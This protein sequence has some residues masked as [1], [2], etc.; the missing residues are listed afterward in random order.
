M[1]AL[2]FILG[3]YSIIA[4]LGLSALVKGVAQ[5]IGARERL[6]LYWVHTCWI[7]ILFGIQIVAW[8]GLWQLR[9]HTAWS[10]LEA[11]MLLL[12]PI[13]FN[14][15]S[16]LAAPAL[17]EGSEFDMRTYYFQQAQ[18]MQGLLFLALLS[19][20]IAVR[21]VAGRWNMN[22]VDLLRIATMLILLPGIFSRRPGIH[23]TQMICLLLVLALAIQRVVAPISGTA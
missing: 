21:I 19:G 11:Q 14:A 1:D 7:I 3:L 2:D 15:V 13:F 22:P 6:R 5:M 18:W 10:M 17:G 16:C 4:G 12:T 8:F 23:A 9:E 20:S